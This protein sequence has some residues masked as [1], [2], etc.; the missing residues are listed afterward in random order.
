MAY[1]DLGCFGSPSNRT[2]AID[3]LARDGVRLTQY[4]VAHVDC[5]PS[6][7]GLLTGRQPWRSGIVD[8]LRSDSPIGLPGEEITMA[9]A[10]RGLGYAT[11]AIG[12]WHLGD[13]PESLPT[14]HGFDG[15][16]GLP[17]SM[18]MAPTILIRDEEIV[19]ELPG[20]AVADLTG[21]YTDEATR[22]LEEDRE[23]P[24]FLYLSHTLPHPPLN[25]P[26]R[27]RGDGRPAY[28]DAIEYLDAE[29]GRLLGA[30]DRLGLADSTLI[31]FTS[32]NGPM[33]AEGDAG[34]LRGR[35]RDSYEGG[36]RVPFVARFP[37]RIPP[38]R[39]VDEPVVAFDLFPT[40]VTLAG[41]TPP[42]DRELDG[43]DVWSLL[44]GSG[45]VDR[46]SPFVWAYDDEVT[47]VRSGRWKLLLGNQDV[48]FPSAMRFDVEADPGE[49]NDL[50]AD[51]PD[52]VAGLRGFAEEYE[53][54]LP[55]VWTLR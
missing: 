23:G 32:D 3:G 52:V 55:V 7:A 10:L 1:R 51:H 53:R 35:I 2:P 18:D 14:N 42:D 20:D 4:C 40:L 33:A 6:R 11:M 38:G 12:K 19:E 50:A 9:E 36:L 17:Y 28:N 21:R 41:G 49:A 37:G 5:S 25:I 27:F 16:L 44:D 15:N 31:V 29:N 24:F 47:A 46:T 48:R 13:R 8:V 30:I 45:T 54:Q 39:V 43:Q 22:F 34:P 26:G